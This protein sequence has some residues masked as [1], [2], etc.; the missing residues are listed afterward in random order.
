MYRECRVSTLQPG[1]ERF[2]VQGLEFRVQGLERLISTAAPEALLLAEERF[3]VWG[4]GF[5]AKGFRFRVWGL[6]FWVGGLDFR[7]QGSGNRAPALNGTG[8]PR[9]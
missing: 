1:V 9:S 2:G 6:W 8:V 7:V 3:G 4:L 5:R